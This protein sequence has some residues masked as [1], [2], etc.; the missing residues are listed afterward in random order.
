MPDPKQPPRKDG[1]ETKVDPPQ[2]SQ[3]RPY[4]PPR[5]VSRDKLEGR[6]NVCDAFTGKTAPPSCGVNRS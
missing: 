6:A 5:I 3:R 2:A 4:E 1:E